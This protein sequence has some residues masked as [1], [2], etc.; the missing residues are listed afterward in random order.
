M[1]IIEYGHDEMGYHNKDKEVTYLG[2]DSGRHQALPLSLCYALFIRMIKSIFSFLVLWTP[3][4]YHIFSFPNSL[5]KCEIMLN[6][7]PVVFYVS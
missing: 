6:V 1:E 4:E 3:L 5:F 7:E 2:V